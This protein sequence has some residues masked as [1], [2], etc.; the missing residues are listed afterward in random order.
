MAK[1]TQEELDQIKK[2]QQFYNQTVFELG[3]NEAQSIV[4]NKQLEKLYQE[5]EK[6]V[7]DLETLELKETQLTQEL[8]DKYGQG[9]INI[10]TGEIKPV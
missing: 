8:Q 9:T 6:L 4:L 3:K 1:L 2:L 7:K 5:K 10:E